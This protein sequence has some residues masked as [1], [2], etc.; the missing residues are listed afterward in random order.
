MVLFCAN[1]LR[2]WVISVLLMTVQI[3]AFAQDEPTTQST[4]LVAED[5][6][7]EVSAA[8]S[9][10]VAKVRSGVVVRVVGKNLR[11]NSAQFKDVAPKQVFLIEGAQPGTVAAR[12]EIAKLSKSKKTAIARVLKFES[13]TQINELVNLFFYTEK[14]FLLRQLKQVSAQVSTS[15]PLGRN[16]T[17]ISS[18]LVGMRQSVATNIITGAEI[19][20]NLNTVSGELSL[21][22]PASV[23]L[24][25]NKFGLHVSYQAAIPATLI[26]GVVSG[27]QDQTIKISE[28]LVEPSIVFRSG[29]S[30]KNLSRYQ[31]GIGYRLSDNNFKI[32]SGT[33]TG[34][35]EISLKQNGPFFG[36]SADFSLLPFLYF[37]LKSQAGIPQTYKA[38]DS[39]IDST[40]E[41]KWNVYNA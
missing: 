34:N 17:F 36:L 38:T 22:M 14:D 26:A 7:K 11:L 2:L 10:K 9:G 16:P 12:I 41:G 23:S 39:S 33:G 1:V 40:L 3:A 37:G 30:D 6:K 35:T 29:Y 18:L 20:Q 28:N 25:V 19:N 31:V 8:T 13:V 24:L 21:F 27:K 32:E 4:G 5:I 15:L